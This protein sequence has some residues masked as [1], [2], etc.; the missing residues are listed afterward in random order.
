MREADKESAAGKPFHFFLMTTS[1]HRPFTFPDG[2][3]DLP[4]KESGRQGGVKYTD[5]AIGEFIRKASVK[6][7]FKNTIFVVVADHCASSA[8]KT[9]LPV[10]KYHIPLLIYAPGGQIAPGKNSTLMSQMDYAPTLLGL[11]GWSYPSRFFGHDV[12]QIQHADDAHALIGT[13]Q[14]LGHMEDGKLTVL[15]PQQIQS[16]YA[17]D[18]ASAVMTPLKTM[19]VEEEDEAIS[20]YQMAEEMFNQRSYQALNSEELNR[21]TAKGELLMTKKLAYRP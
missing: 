13:Y 2:Q 19:P 17:V 20:Y 18:L 4:S 6:P 3:I 9:E 12:R 21:W 10:A 16:F 8:G 5:Y 1:N 7:W 14:K 11:L 15:A